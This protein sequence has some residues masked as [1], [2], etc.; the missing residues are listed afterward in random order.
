MKVDSPLFQKE[1]SLILLRKIL[2]HLFESHTL[3]LSFQEENVTVNF[4]EKDLSYLVEEHIN[5]Y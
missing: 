2:C 3:K 5:N 4:G 1:L